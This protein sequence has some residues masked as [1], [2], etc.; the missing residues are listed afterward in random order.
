MDKPTI[1]HIKSIQAGVLDRISQ[2][3]QFEQLGTNYRTELLA[4]VTTFMTLAPILV[5]NA[6]LL[7][8]AI[9][10]N[11]VGD[12]F[13]QILAAITLCSAFASIGIGV[14]ANHPIALIPGTGTIALFSFSIVLGMG[15]NWRLALTGYGNDCCLKRT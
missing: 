5:V 14:L 11:Q 3:F 12:L 4:S 2:F 8:N 10:L 15:M 6:H 1:T 13:E 9:F 7:G